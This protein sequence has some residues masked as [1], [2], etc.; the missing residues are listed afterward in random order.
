M[1]GG[2]F[3]YFQELLGQFSSTMEQKLHHWEGRYNDQK[4]W[5]KKVKILGQS[6][7]SKY[8]VEI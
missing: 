4:N 1:G 5:S 6:S 3:V 8:L 2:Y 7:K